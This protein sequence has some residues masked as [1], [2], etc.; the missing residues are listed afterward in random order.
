MFLNQVK[1]PTAV[2]RWP[3]SGRSSGSSMYSTM[4]GSS[5]SKSTGLYNTGCLK[6]KVGDSTAD[7]WKMTRTFKE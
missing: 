4:L 2:Q 5:D 3:S 7:I 1:R 6:K